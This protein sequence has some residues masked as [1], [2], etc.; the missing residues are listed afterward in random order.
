MCYNYC[1]G[2]DIMTLDELKEL[3]SVLMKKKNKQDSYII[4]E[5]YMKI[6]SKREFFSSIKYT[7]EDIKKLENTDKMIRKLKKLLKKDTSLLVNNINDELNSLSLCSLTGAIFKSKYIDEI[8]D[9]FKSSPL[10]V[11]YDLL[12]SKLLNENMLNDYAFLEF[13]LSF[14]NTFVGT[15]NLIDYFYN[16]E[17]K[18]EKSSSDLLNELKNNKISGI[19]R[20]NEFVKKITDLGYQ[21]QFK[22]DI[23]NCNNNYGGFSSAFGTINIVADL[24]SKKVK[25]K[26]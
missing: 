17:K 4:V 18:C 6:F 14:E 3:K 7:L 8:K 9:N 20:Y 11:D 15:N 13:S 10:E 16:R 23:N 26:K 5:D 22:S 21:I 12:T 1:A 19:V 2:G 25:K 24:S